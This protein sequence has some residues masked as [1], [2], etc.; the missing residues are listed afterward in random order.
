MRDQTI[1]QGIGAR[2]E[3]LRRT[4][5]LTDED[6]ATGAR[7]LGL[8]WSRN[9]VLGIER[10]KR[11]LNV[12]EFLLLPQ[13]LERVFE[14][15]LGT[16]KRVSLEELLP[17][18]R[19]DFGGAWIE[20]SALGE[21]LRGGTLDRARIHATSEED[22]PPKRIRRPGGVELAALR[23]LLPDEPH[24][25][26]QIERDAL[27]D[28]ES[29]LARALGTLPELIVMAS[30]NTWGRTLTHERDARLDELDVVTEPPDDP[31]KRV[32]KLRALRG[33]ITRSLTEEIQDQ[34]VLVRQQLLEKLTTWLGLGYAVV[35]EAGGDAE[36]R[37]AGLMSTISELV[38]L[39]AR[40]RYGRS[41][42]AELA[43]RIQGG[44]LQPD[45]K[46]RTIA[47]MALELDEPLALVRRSLE[48]GEVPTRAM[49]TEGLRD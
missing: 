44:G 26:A 19:I 45:F 49:A 4:K 38:V 5:G 6:I 24:R 17:D 22:A 23:K 11:G 28:A 27:G 14:R 39:A 37:L 46:T 10:G 34:L 7:D 21:L 9:T 32:K 30:V 2:L 35:R 16:S 48:G 1:D 43:E 8:P 25:A 36:R 42:S 40:E 18:G 47:D 20:G 33:H 3:D 29:K 15:T 41:A 31:A 12:A 13:V